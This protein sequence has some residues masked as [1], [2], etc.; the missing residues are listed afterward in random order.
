MLSL[1]HLIIQEYGWKLLCTFTLH[2]FNDDLLLELLTALCLLVRFVSNRIDIKQWSFK[3]TR[4]HEGYI[5]TVY[6]VSLIVINPLVQLLFYIIDI[7]S[8]EHERLSKVLLFV[9]SCYFILYSL[10]LLCA[11]YITIAFGH[12][13]YNLLYTVRIWSDFVALLVLVFKF[14]DFKYQ[15]L[16]KKFR[17]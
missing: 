12:V 13:K 4:Y 2:V 16:L 15:T 11:H 5:S 8:Y 10:Y 1:N 9:C 6:M 3:R 17:P 14:V 7:V